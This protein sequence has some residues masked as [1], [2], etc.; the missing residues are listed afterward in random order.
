M[1]KTLRRYYRILQTQNLEKLTW[2]HPIIET[3]I[4]VSVP[5][6]LEFTGSNHFATEALFA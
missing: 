2:L 3:A 5:V 1:L 6:L 4:R